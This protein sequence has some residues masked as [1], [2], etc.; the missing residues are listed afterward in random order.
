MGISINGQ[1]K[2]NL[3]S[4][5]SGMQTTQKNSSVPAVRARGFVELMARTNFSFLQGASHPEEMVTEA[6]VHGYDGIGVC[7]LN[8]LYGVVRGFQTMQSPSLFKASKKAKEGFHYLIGSEL[9]LTDET[10]ITLIPINKQGYSHLCELL[11]LGKRQAAKGFSKL[12]L[13]Q[14]EKYNQGLLCLALPPWTDERYERLEKIFDDRLYLPVWRDLTWESHEHCRSAFA[15]EE[16]YQARLF[17]TQRPF[18]HHPE[19]KYLFDVLTCILHHTTLKEAKNKLIQNAERCLKSLEDLSFLWQDR[20]DLVEKTVEIAA[21]VKFSLDEIRYRYPHSQLPQGLTPSEHLRNLA[22]EGAKKRFPSG[23]PEKVSKMIDYELA[24]IKELEYEDYFLTLKEICDFATEKDILHQGRGSAANSVVCFCIGLTSVN[25]NEI[26]LLFERFISRERREP[27][28]IDIDFEHNRRE[29]VIQHIYEKYNER[30]AAMVCTVIR[31]RSRMAIRETAKVFGIPLSKINEMIKFMGRDGMSRL[32]EPEVGQ[33]FGLAPHE[34]KLFLAMAQ[35]LHGFPRHLGIHTGGFLITQDPITEMVPVEKATMNDRY[36]IQWNKDDV[37]TL[38]LMKIDVLSLGMLTCLK[39][40]FDLLKTH[41]NRP[42]E[43][44]TIPANDQPTYEMIGRADTVGVFQIESRAQMQ[45]LPRMKPKDFYDLVIEV[46][47][48]RPG[49]LQGGMVHP[50]LRRRQGLEKAHYAH[51]RLKP[52]LEKTFGVPIFQ[53][54]VMKIVIEVADFTPGEADELRRIMSSAWRKRSTMEGIKQ[55]ILAGFAKYEITSEYGEQIYKTI[56]G[57]ANYG[58][59]ESHAASFAILTYASC[60]IKHHYP[61]VFACGLLNSQPM[62][63][64]A[65]RTLIAEAQ[66]NGVEVR[67]LCIQHSDYDYTLET[68]LVGHALRVGMRSLYGVPEVLLRRIE[69]SRRQ[70]GEFK[71]LADFIR[72]TQLPRAALVKI[73]GAGALSCFNTNVRELIWHLESLSLDQESFLWGHPKEQFSLED[74]DDEPEHLPFE[75]NWDRLRREYDSKGF[76]VDSHPLSV[77]RS[78]LKSKSSELVAKRYVPYFNSADL[79]KMK[80]KCKVRL[81]GLVSVT[82]RPPTAKGMC[83]ITLEDEF[84]FM[85]IVIHPD[86]YQ[87]DRMAIYGRSL[88]EVHGTI[89]KVGELINIRAERVLPLQ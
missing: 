47:L 45:T 70:D 56:E 12:T 25:P 24:L 6:I 40:C 8:G 76:S 75:S 49:P 59:P 22:W 23:I 68:N 28:D 71:D 65:P 27:P 51:D 2:I 57:F 50:Y 72:R 9:T 64:Y 42:L 37:A 10:S 62:G 39:K 16:K 89:E 87:K 60:Y 18:M 35:Q 36:V 32:L 34:W 86:V 73:A 33:K 46:A 83:F 66:R 74:Q 1:K 19:R 30:H 29:E 41:K 54:Q 38:K 58:F 4:R 67:P 17:V 26:D 3:P 55:R 21:R 79:P 63:F 31:Y 53:E 77:L 88:L 81:A 48:V 85:N 7:D 69:E 78:Y 15:L 13:E 20:L 14:V 44:H 80:N 84:G 11:T 52:I 61:D 43:L 5:M 82:Q